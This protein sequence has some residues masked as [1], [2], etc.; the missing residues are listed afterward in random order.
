MVWFLLLA[1]TGLIADA[2]AVTVL[3]GPAP[4]VESRD[5]TAVL[6][7][8]QEA[9]GRQLPDHEFMDIHGRPVRLSSFRGK[10][11]VISLIYTSCY[12]TCPMITQSLAR[13]VNVGH[14]ALGEGL[15]RVTIIDTPNI[16]GSHASIR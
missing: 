3:H 12:H 11:F 9:I 8:S 14:E 1:L 16:A 4:A 10:P 5:P 15:Y 7:L 6:R 13:V 2:H